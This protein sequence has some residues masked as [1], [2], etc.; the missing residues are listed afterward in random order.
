MNLEDWSA[1]IDYWRGG[2]H[3]MRHLDVPAEVARALSE[4]EGTVA[5][6][7]FLSGPEF[8]ALVEKSYG[9]PEHVSDEARAVLSSMEPGFEDWAR[10]E[11]DWYEI[12]QQTRTEMMTA[13]IQQPSNEPPNEPAA[14]NEPK[15]K[16][17]A[18]FDGTECGYSGCTRAADGYV[19]GTKPTKGGVQGALWFGPACAACVRKWHPSLRP[20]TLAELAYQR[21]GASDLAL[22]LDVEVGDVLKRL[23]LAGIDERGQPFHSN[24]QAGQAVLAA[25]GAPGAALAAQPSAGVYVYTDPVQIPIEAL[26][27]QRSYVQGVLQQLSNWHINSQSDMDYAST[28]VAQVKGMWASLEEQRKNLVKPLREKIEAVQEYFKPV[29]GDLKSLETVGKQK[30]SEG[31]TRAQAAQQAAYEAAQRALQSGD[32]QGA[33]LATQQAVSADITLAPGVGIRTEIAFEIVDY[34]QLPQDFWSWVPDPAKVQAAVDAGHRQ[35]PGVRIFEKSVV[36]SRS[37]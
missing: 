32:T 29:L 22:V 37:A 5:A 15:W 14:K 12:F 35:I 27:A 21:S 20:A 17:K 16:R 6:T 28:F 30:I 31:N 33:A 2:G 1:L 19:S 10:T 13:E 4:T 23:A 26:A 18:Y 24:A 36:S 34:R 9:G 11:A 8:K 7:R 3:D 25:E